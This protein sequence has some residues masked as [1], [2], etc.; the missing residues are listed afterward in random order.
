[1]SQASSEF[2]EYQKRLCEEFVDEGGDPAMFWA[3][4]MSMWIGHLRMC[5]VGNLSEIILF[6]GVCQIEYDDIIFART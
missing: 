2:R 3:G 4:R 5:R 1:M 6:L